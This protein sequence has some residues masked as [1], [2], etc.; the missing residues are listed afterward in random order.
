MKIELRDV[1]KGPSRARALDPT[2]TAFETGSAVLVEA[3]TEQRPTVLGLI[4]SGRMKPDSGTVLLDGR[5]DTRAIRIR[6]ALVDAPE[7]CDPAPDVTVYGLVEEELMFAGRAANLLSARRWLDDNGFA[8]IGRMPIAA[9]AP[10][11]R[12]SLLLELTALRSRVEAIVLVSPDRHGGDPREWWGIAHDFA[13]RGY[14]VLVIAGIASAMVLRE[15]DLALP[16]S[17]DA[18][19]DDAAA[20]PAADA[21]ATADDAPA[22]QSQTTDPTTTHPQKPTA[23]PETTNDTVQ[24]S[25]TTEP[26]TTHPQKPTVE[27]ETTADDDAQQSQT[28]DPAA[29]GPH[30]LTVERGADIEPADEPGEP[31]E[32]EPAEHDTATDDDPE[33]DER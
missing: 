24:P 18:A 10:R 28:T 22:Q 13:A 23:E 6:T 25:Q 17:T 11:V 16:E 30:E 12:I 4:A 20:S 5:A 8:G 21:E 15:A 29:A 9:V 3:E 19:A 26:T 7:V 2:S 27:P 1:A 32:P 31:G 14:A 33:E